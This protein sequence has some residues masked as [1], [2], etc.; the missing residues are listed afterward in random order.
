MHALEV[1]SERGG[2]GVADL[3]DAGEVIDLRA[4]DAYKARIAELRDDL[5]EAERW[6]DAGR[7]AR[8]RAELA[9][10]TEQIAAAVGLGSR[11]RRSGSAAERA[12]VTVQRRIRQ[13]IKKIAVHDANLG[14]TDWPS[15]R[16]LLRV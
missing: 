1:V 15:D 13:A 5:T 11:A 3:G 10:L 14:A 2:E 6:S 12:R 7:A 9:A 16:N 8:I 4:R